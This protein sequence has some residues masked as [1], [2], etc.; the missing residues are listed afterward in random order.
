MW[1]HNFTLLAIMLLA[2]GFG[3]T[4]NHL[5]DR[6]SN[7]EGHS[8]IRSVVI[9]TAAS[10]LVPLFLNTISSTLLTQSAA[11]DEKLLV[12]SGLCIIAAISS[13]AFI[14]RISAKVLQDVQV[15]QKN[16]QDMRAGM[17]VLLETHTEPEHI[18]QSSAGFRESLPLAEGARAVLRSLAEGR[19]ALRSAEGISQDAGVGV[20]QITADLD[21]LASMGLA[22][23]WD[24]ARGTRW[25][26]TSRGCEFSR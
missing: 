7:R 10:L 11:D 16:V 2:G 4:V 15:L 17:D 25:A 3:G 1:N 24:G 20:D 22:R 8:L 14:R 13:S 12:F 19:F 18:R 23:R 26:A 9:G 5:L 21:L 6:R